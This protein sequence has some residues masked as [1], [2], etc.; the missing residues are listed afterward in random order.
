MHALSCLETKKPPQGRFAVWLLS[1]SFDAKTKKP[2]LRGLG[3]LPIG[4][5]LPENYHKSLWCKTPLTNFAIINF[6]SIS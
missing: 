6:S 3:L 2:A 4:T 1:S 5:S